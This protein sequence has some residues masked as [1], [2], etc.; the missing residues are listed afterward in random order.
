VEETE[1]M[2]VLMPSK[3]GSHLNQKPPET[4]S[5]TNS[6]PKRVPIDQVNTSPKEEDQGL[7]TKEDLRRL[8][9]TVD[10]AIRTLAIT[11]WMKAAG[12]ARA[13]EEDKIVAGLAPLFMG[14]APPF[15]L[16]VQMVWDGERGEAAAM[17][18]LKERLPGDGVTL[19]VGL[20]MVQQLLTCTAALE[21]VAG[22]PDATKRVSRRD[23]VEAV[24]DV[25]VVGR[26]MKT[27]QL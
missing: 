15:M 7:H 8:A 10:E 5:L 6:R 21:R 25:A 26:W 18:F 12:G 24:K 9:E 1:T 27:Q 11:P 3:M 16:V 4:Q 17:S 23:L 19:R 14:L 20:R 13:M 2:K 22:V